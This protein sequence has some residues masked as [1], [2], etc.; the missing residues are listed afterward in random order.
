MEMMDTL[1][2]DVLAMTEINT[3]WTKEVQTICQVYGRKI[4]GLFRKVGSSSDKISTSLYQPGEVA[5]FSKGRI[6]G[7]INKLGSNEKG[8]S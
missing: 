4:V 3:S 8:F 5:I 2:I 1:D 6:T 7:R